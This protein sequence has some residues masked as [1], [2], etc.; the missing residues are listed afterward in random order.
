MLLVA[1]L[2][3]AAVTAGSM[4]PPQPRAGTQATTPSAP[5]QVH[6]ADIDGFTGVTGTPSTVSA[7]CG[8][9]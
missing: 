2:A 3:A 5:G 7:Y 6:T 8:S 1:V 4:L 9:R